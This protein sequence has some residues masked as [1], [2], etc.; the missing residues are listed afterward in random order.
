M[1][2]YPSTQLT[3]S[4]LRGALGAESTKNKLAFAHDPFADRARCRLGHSEPFHILDISAAIADEMVMPHPFCVE[5]CGSPLDRDFA[6]ES[7][8]HQIPQIVVRRSPGGTR[9]HAI[10]CLE[11]FCSRGMTVTFHQECHYCV[12]L[13]RTPQ[14]AALQRLLDRLGMQ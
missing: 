8:L 6:H 14:P 1:C 10:D 12:T 5:T 4:A 7:R 3:R 9:I 11:N 2:R 13:R